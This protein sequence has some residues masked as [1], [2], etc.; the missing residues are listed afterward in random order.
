MDATLTESEVSRLRSESEVERNRAWRRVYDESFDSVYRLACRSGVHTDEA[1]EICQ[2][3]FAIAHRKLGEA[4][5]IANLQGWLYGITL[6]VVRQHFRW[7]RVRQVKAWV[8]P[9]AHGVVPAEMP[10]PEAAATHT[11]LQEKVNQVLC[12]MSAKLREVL[13]L[14]EIE[15]LRPQEAAEILAIPVNTVRSRRR[16]AQEDFRRRWQALGEELSTP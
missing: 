15:D 8:L 2:K 12:N 16:L 5:M 13:V 1:E 10:S 3:V 7:Q 4:G 9:N 6:R 11:E 14:V